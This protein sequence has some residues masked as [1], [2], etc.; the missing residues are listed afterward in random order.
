MVGDEFGDP[1]EHDRLE[2]GAS[3]GAKSV[4]SGL[5][6]EGI[7]PRSVTGF[8]RREA[9][10]GGEI[11]LGLRDVEQGP[12]VKPRAGVLERGRR[13]Q[14]GLKVRLSSAGPRSDSAAAGSG[15]GVDYRGRRGGSE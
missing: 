12:V 8:D 1:R 7:E 4:T 5:A 9:G 15:Q 3:T 6:Q 10:R 11:F 13:L 2:I 14:E